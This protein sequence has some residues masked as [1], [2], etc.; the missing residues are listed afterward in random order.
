MRSCPFTAIITMSRNLTH[1]V[2][3]QTV[4]VRLPT[5]GQGHV[6]SRRRPPLPTIRRNIRVTRHLREGE[7]RLPILHVRSEHLDILPPSC[8]VIEVGGFPRIRSSRIRRRRRRRGRPGEDGA[9]PSTGRSAALLPRRQSPGDHLWG[10][11][12]WSPD[13][14]GGGTDGEWFIDEEGIEAVLR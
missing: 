11:D 5:K 1:D 14:D 2:T 10:P 13:R 9:S 7:E 8:L 4:R 3:P 12:A 6:V